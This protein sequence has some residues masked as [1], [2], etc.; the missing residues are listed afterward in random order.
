LLL[1]ATIT[2]SIPVEEDPLRGKVWYMAVLTLAA[3][4]PAAAQDALVGLSVPDLEASTRWYIEKMGMEI[5]MEPPPHEGTQVR[6]L[7]GS[8]LTVELIQVPGA[9]PG[10]DD[11]TR[12][13]GIFKVGVMVDDID[14]ILETL[15]SRRVAIAFGP[16]PAS[17]TQP[18]N[19]IVRDNAGNLLQ[20]VA[21]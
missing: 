2:G 8:G 14:A 18:A 17:A 1:P 11:P 20:F 19:F 5:V 21:R 15:R 4:S 12:L 3:A 9:L 13:H 6:I 7:R 10:P 16:F